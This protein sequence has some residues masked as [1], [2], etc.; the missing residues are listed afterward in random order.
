M[1]GGMN[2]RVSHAVIVSHI[3]G[4]SSVMCSDVE[5]GQ[6]AHKVVAMLVVHV[7]NIAV[8]DR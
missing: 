3:C 5:T 4:R 8:V 1:K 7:L 6:Q 2:A